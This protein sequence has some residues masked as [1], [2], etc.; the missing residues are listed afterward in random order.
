M[1]TFKDFSGT[2]GEW[3]TAIIAAVT[4]AAKHVLAVEVLHLLSG[5]MKEQTLVVRGRR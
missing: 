3:M 4:E 5:G 1:F 2:R